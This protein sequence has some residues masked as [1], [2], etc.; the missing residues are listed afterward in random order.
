[1][2]VHGRCALSAEWCPNVLLPSRASFGAK[3]EEQDF[4]LRVQ[5]ALFQCVAPFC[6]LA[7]LV[8]RVVGVP[9]PFCCQCF[10]SVSSFSRPQVG[11]AMGV[12]LDPWRLCFSSSAASVG[13]AVAP[14]P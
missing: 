12:T 1:M 13:D 4:C 7:S 9:A 6:D 8:A 2:R 5:Q 10:Y 14:P 11:K 3:G